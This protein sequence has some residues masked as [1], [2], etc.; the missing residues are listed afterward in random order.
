MV[1][2]NTSQP[3]AEVKNIKIKAYEGQN[4]SKSMQVIREINT[5]S[6]EAISNAIFGLVDT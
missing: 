5:V 6:N 3:R 1:E 4:C 2:Y